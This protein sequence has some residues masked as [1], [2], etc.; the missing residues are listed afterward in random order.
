MGRDTHAL[1]EP[2]WSTALEV[3]VANDVTV[4]VDD[5]DGYTPT[6]AVSHAILRANHGRASGLADGIV[7]T[8]SHNPPADGGFKYNPPNGGPAASDATSWIQD[9]ANEIIRGGLKDV[10]R[11]PYAHPVYTAAGMEAQTRHREISGRRRTHYCG[12]Y[13]RY[14]FH[15]DG[16]VSALRVAEA[17]GV[18]W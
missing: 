8:P 5:R 6:P 3:L 7:V 4:L 11:I 18:R 12:A 15:E 16:L 9:R 13:W 1:S 17:L 2:A 14:G 10:R